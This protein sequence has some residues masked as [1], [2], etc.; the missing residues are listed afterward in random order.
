MEISFENEQ[1]P[2]DIEKKSLVD[3]Y[4]LQFYNTSIYKNVTIIPQKEIF[5]FKKI[6]KH[7]FLTLF[8][9]DI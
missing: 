8:L 6:L 4:I 7:I 9:F 5:N 1:K 3:F 2:T